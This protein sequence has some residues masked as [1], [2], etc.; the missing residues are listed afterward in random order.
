M[1]NV[2]LDPLPKEWKGY[3]I[4]SDFQT[5]IQISQCLADQSLS[6]NERFFTAA[7]LL[8]P[9]EWPSYEEVAKAVN[10]WMNG[11]NHDNNK[12]E[13]KSDVKVMDWDID[14]WRLYAAFMG[15]YR[16]DL[17]TAKLHWFTFMGLLS[18]LEECAFTNVMNI[19]QKKIN[20][21]MSQEEKNSI[22]AA[23]RLFSIKPPKEAAL[24]P[25]EQQ[26]VNEFMKYAGLDK[27]K[28]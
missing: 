17:N 2:L 22:R 19:R 13:K 14:Q 9:K 28:T 3:P 23:Q 27:K 7:G 26:R 21:K 20:S 4:D 10:W 8:F 24:S 16:I 11:Y 18:N 6:E 15:Q 5:G 25:R 12:K 1:W